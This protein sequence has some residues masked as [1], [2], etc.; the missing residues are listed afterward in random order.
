MTFKQT[1][2]ILT[3]T[4]I[5]FVPSF[6]MEAPEIDSIDKIAIDH[7]LLAFNAYDKEKSQEQPTENNRVMGITKKWNTFPETILQGWSFY[8]VM[9]ETGCHQLSLVT[10]SLLGIVGYNPTL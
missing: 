6:S 1:T 5:F 9:G 8:N 3:L 7:T 4:A 2:Q 10:Q